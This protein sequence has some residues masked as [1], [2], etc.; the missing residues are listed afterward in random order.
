MRSGQSRSC[1]QNE[2]AESNA[3][4]VRLF[5]CRASAAADVVGIYGKF[6]VAESLTFTATG[7]SDSAVGAAILPLR[8]T[9]CRPARCAATSTSSATRDFSAR[10]RVHRKSKN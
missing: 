8:I 10:A 7:I 5:Y 2:L 6:G 9:R 3:A 4:E 1:R